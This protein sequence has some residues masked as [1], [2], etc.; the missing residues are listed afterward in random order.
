M[1]FDFTG[2]INW[3]HTSPED[4]TKDSLSERTDF[5]PASSS[6]SD[7]G[8]D[9]ADQPERHPID[10]LPD[11]TDGDP[12]SSS[13]YHGL[14]SGDQPDEH[15]KDS[16]PEGKACD[17]PSSSTD[18]GSSSGDQPD[19]H[20]KDALPE[21]T[22]SLADLNGPLNTATDIPE[23]PD[24]SIH[25]P[26]TPSHVNDGEEPSSQEGRLQVS[27]R[28][29]RYED[30]GYLVDKT[31]AS[32]NCSGS[33]LTEQLPGSVS[34]A[35]AEAQRRLQQDEKM[36]WAIE[37]SKPK[38]LVP[39][40][41]NFA[42]PEKYQLALYKITKD[43]NLRPKGKSSG[44]WRC[45]K[46][47]RGHKIYTQPH[48]QHPLSVLSCECTH[49]SCAKCKLEGLI[50]QFQPMSDPA[51]VHLSED[52][53]RAIR[54]GVF[55]EGCGLSWRAQRVPVEVK[56]T[57]KKSALQC[58]STLPRF[59]TKR[60]GGAPT[61]KELR[62]SRSMNNLHD[63]TESRPQAAPLAASRSSLDLR[64]LSKEMRKE[65][66]E[67]AEPVPVKFASIQ[68]TCTMTTADSS[69]C[70][71]IMD[72]P[73]DHNQT[74]LVKKVAARKPAGFGSTPEDIARGHGTPTL[75]LRGRQH[76]NPLRSNLVA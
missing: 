67:Q 9:L 2:D 3:S 10:P 26:D 23:T 45:C 6:S 36:K 65:H 61:L 60:G 18:C 49:R 40:N 47:N 41:S 11:R 37:V 52:R 69:L 35:R 43:P 32:Y 22:Y 12:S 73:K 30:L 72:K 20:T 33:K 34:H 4:H 44:K 42:S 13:S 27:A 56:K 57:P 74:Q 15:T 68:C 24:I 66:G 54:F 1:D 29:D 28:E 25:A 59:L 19:G 58:V 64:A 51:V 14:G 55:C 76:P 17:W 38:P 7:H 39:S 70:F 63:P 5:D 21:R 53:A 8:P 16:D 62:S 31:G 46:C 71:Q 75:T 48:P 50:K